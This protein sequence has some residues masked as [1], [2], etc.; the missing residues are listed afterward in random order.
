MLTEKLDA[1][2]EVRYLNTR[3]SLVISTFKT[4][5]QYNYKER[6]E[7]KLRELAKMV[8]PGNEDGQDDFIEN[9]DNLILDISEDP[10]Q[11]GRLRE[12]LVELL[13]GVPE[14]KRDEIFEFTRKLL[15]EPT[16]I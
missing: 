14:H 9:F 8:H 2:G 7:A 6:Y 13:E 3:I 5:E 10:L 11:A 16:F 15:F 12:Q 1:N 4:K